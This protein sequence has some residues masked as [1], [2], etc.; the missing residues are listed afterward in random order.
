MLSKNDRLFIAPRE[1]PSI[2]FTLARPSARA[3]PARGEGGSTGALVDVHDVFA[4]DV[5]VEQ[6]LLLLRHV[7]QKPRDEKR[8]LRGENGKVG[9][10]ARLVV[11]RGQRLALAA[12]LVKQPVGADRTKRQVVPQ[13]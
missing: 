3:K 7:G 2:E 1:C 12:V 11:Q 8:E 9:E 10:C 5:G 4:D 6:R 13:Q